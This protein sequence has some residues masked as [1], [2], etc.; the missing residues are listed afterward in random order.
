MQQIELTY[1][2]YDTEETLDVIFYRPLGYYIAL[3]CKKLG[4]TPNMVTIISLVI[5]VTSGH[6]F[7]YK[8]I[9]LNILGIAFLIFA[10]TLDSAD[11]QLARIT[12]IHSRYGRV[13]DGFAGNL[14]FLSIYIHICLRMMNE[15][16]AGYWIF[17]VALIAAI[18]HSLQSAMADLYRNAYMYFVQNKKT[19]FDRLPEIQKKYKSL[20]WKKNF[21]KKFLMWIY[22][23]HSM[24]QE[25]LSRNFSMLYSAS[26]KI[27]PGSSPSW[28]NEKYKKLNKSLLK[29]YNILTT[30]TRMIVLFIAIL[31]GYLYI[32]FIFELT[33]LNLL[34]LFVTIKQEKNSQELYNEIKSI[35]LQK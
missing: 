35:T 1:K 8:D 19:E 12:G 26:V 28:V 27:F 16:T 20:T 7:Y 21:F 13:L 10:E 22:I 2:S 24:E 29:Y 4:V 31:S 9:N 18:S 17:G 5:G 14:M 15:G 33:I 32:Y 23:G 25:I 30:N 34:L 6:L 3:F 11:G